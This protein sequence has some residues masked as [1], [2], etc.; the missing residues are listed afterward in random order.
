MQKKFLSVSSWHYTIGSP[1]PLP[2]QETQPN[3]EFVNDKRRPRKEVQTPDYLLTPTK[4]AN[5]SI[6]SLE[7]VLT[8]T[9]ENPE[10][11]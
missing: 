2:P 6:D 9:Q 4:G 7:L 11:H 10:Q 1:V 5:V 8:P 3:T